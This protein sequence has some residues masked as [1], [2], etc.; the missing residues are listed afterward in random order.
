MKKLLSLL[1]VLSLVMSLCVIPAAAEDPDSLAA[2]E[3]L[4]QA[5]SEGLAAL[6]GEGADP[7]EAAEEDP[8]E[9]PAPADP[10]EETPVEEPA[11]EDPAEEAPVEE[12]A[13]VDPAEEAPVEEPAPEDPAEEELAE[14][15][16]QEPVVEEELLQAYAVLESGSCGDD[17]TWALDTSGCLTI[18]GTGA[19]GDFRIDRAPW[20]RLR[21]DIV[22]VVIE[23]GVTTISD[24][25]FEYCDSMTSVTIGPDVT[26]IGRGAFSDCD[27]L[28]AVS[29][30]GNVE[31]IGDYAFDACDSLKNVTLAE[32][33][34]SIGENA[35]CWNWE[36]ESI[37][38]PSTVKEIGYGAFGGCENLTLNLSSGNAY[39]YSQNGVIFSADGTRLVVYPAKLTAS[40]YTVPASVTDITAAFMGNQYLKTVTLPSGLEKIGREAFEDCFELTSVNIPSSVTVIDAYAFDYCRALT[41]VTLPE[42]LQIIGEC[43]F[44]ECESLTSITL[45]QDLML[46][47]WGAFRSSALQAVSIPASVET[48]EP[49]AFANCQS[50]TGITVAAGNETYYAEDGVLFGNEYGSVTLLAYPGGKS[51]SIY[52]VDADQVE[53]SAFVGCVNLKE[54]TI[55]SD[56]NVERDAFDYNLRLEAVTVDSGNTSFASKDGVLYELD[57]N[58]VCTELIYYPEGKSDAVYDVPATVQEVWYD[59]FSQSQVKS[60]LF[61]EGLTTLCGS[62]FDGCENLESIALPVSLETVQ[63]HTFPDFSNSIIIDVYYAG[64][65]SQWNDVLIENYNQ[66]LDNATMHYNAAPEDVPAPGGGGTTPDPEPDTYTGLRLDGDGVWRYY[67]NGV[68]QSGYTGLVQHSDGNF[69]YVASGAIDFTYTGLVDYYGVSYYVQGGI[70]YWGVYGLVYVDGAWRYLYNSTFA[71]NFTGLVQHSDGSRFYVVNGLIDFSYTGLVPD[72]DGKYYYI[73]SGLVRSDHTGLVQHTDGYFYYVINGV[74][75]S[76]YTGLVPYGE[77]S[78]YVQGGILYWGV[79][80]LVPTN[81]A[82]YYI[83][84]SAAATNYTGL[85]QHTDGN[86][87]Y[88]EDGTIDWGYT[89]LVW[90]ADGNWYYVS[91]GVVNSSYTGLAL[92]SD[93]YY[94]YVKNGKV[95]GSY[96]GLVAYGSASYY[97]QNGILYWGVNGLVTI[98]TKMYYLS[99]SVLAADYSGPVYHTD[100]KW[101]EVSNGVVV[102][103]MRDRQSDIFNRLGYIVYTY[104]NV[105]GDT[106][107]AY[108]KQFN[109]SSSTEVFQLR[110]DATDSTYWIYDT[111]FMNNGSVYVVMM[112]VTKTLEPYYVIYGYYSAEDA[113]DPENPTAM[114]TASFLPYYLTPDGSIPFTTYRGSVNQSA[115]EEICAID[116]CLAMVLLDSVFDLYLEG[117]SA[118][119]LGFYALELSLASSASAASY[120]MD[121]EDAAQ[122]LAD[123]SFDPFDALRALA[124]QA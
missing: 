109:F 32:G 120:A 113:D 100:G 93:G 121:D 21:D 63:N 40:S 99:N 12:P 26:S 79:Y 22:K 59:A 103:V 33:I 80:G 43:A 84:N 102:S 54:V 56:V 101:Y 61:H 114:A 42:G 89:G 117:T 81:G 23:S 95:D 110:F 92:H 111:S 75:E 66:M 11:P 30:P 90:Y 47:S 1:L 49:G 88:V 104:H 60:V 44:S 36:M 41:D 53:G 96:T 82:W 39:F 72:T 67:V 9:E 45:P 24:W 5:L 31:E 118:Y 8:V 4:G 35:F 38:I 123:T 69:Y 116:V 20:Y 62:A 64:S 18:S 48:I 115:Q 71:S 51:G 55:G 119:D 37:T 86:L 13:P 10:A 25:A 76:S 7:A 15:P 112:Q 28:A 73:I 70:L 50:L 78:Y 97:V 106:Y 34:V 6:D 74:V 124:N 98:G 2:E 46:I 65:R 29:I 68:L 77:L 91:G 19:M 94:Y 16:F 3:K 105:Q 27:A 83:Y 85:V 52:T 87:Y 17:L 108:Q 57:S 14:E 58:G 107:M 122:S